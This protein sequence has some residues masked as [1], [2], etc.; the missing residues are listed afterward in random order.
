MATTGFHEG[1]LAAQRLAGVQGQAQRLEGML[2]HATLSSGAAKFLAQQ[3]FAVL[4]ARDHEGRL[5]TSPLVA[6]AGFLQGLG[7]SLHVRSRF[8][9]GDPLD[10]IPAGQQVGMIAIDFAARRRMRLNG[11]LATA[12]STGLLVQI[13]QAFGNCP[14]YIHPRTVDVP[15]L[16]SAPP[17]GVRHVLSLSE[18]D[19]ALIAG[20]DTFFLGTTHPIRGNDASHR[21]GP[22]GFVR[23]DSPGRLW[24]PDYPGNNMFNSFGNLSVDDEA[25]LLFV[26]FVNGASLH[27]SGRAQVQWNIPHGPGADGAARGVRFQVDSVVA[28]GNSTVMRAERPS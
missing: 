18:S 10:G 2:G 20:A 23:V 16:R 27:V 3:T 8:R 19:R 11:V 22:P 5:W 4:T 13:D 9:D 14:Q 26:D 1:E 21:G 24:W 15:T 25:A 6:A 17:A 12:D 28:L 7:D